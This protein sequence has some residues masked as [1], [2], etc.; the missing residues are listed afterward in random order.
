MATFD[1]TNTKY[2]QSTNSQYYQDLPCQSDYANL[3]F[4][5]AVTKSGQV[6][7]AVK[8][9]F[10]TQSAVDLDLTRMENQLGGGALF[11]RSGKSLVFN[12]RGCF[13][14]RSVVSNVL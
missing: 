1:K 8:L 9:L 11:G 6:T 2:S 13:L 7:K 4:F 5:Y 3:I 10:I 14:F 12:D